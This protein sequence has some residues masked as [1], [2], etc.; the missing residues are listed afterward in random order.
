MNKKVIIFCA[1]ITCL[2]VSASDVMIKVPGMVCQMCVQGMRKGFKDVVND[3]RKDVLVNLENKTVSLK[4][5][6]KITDDEIKKRIK[7]AGYNVSKITWS[8]SKKVKAVK[9]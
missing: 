2:S 7:D 8:K 6:N 3:P 1:L 5:K 9:E 4:L